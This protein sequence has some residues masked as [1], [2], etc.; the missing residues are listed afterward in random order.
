LLI[1]KASSQAN[2]QEKNEARKNQETTKRTSIKIQIRA[3]GKFV[4]P[5]GKSAKT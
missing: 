4:L 5:G 2:K 1:F 3:L